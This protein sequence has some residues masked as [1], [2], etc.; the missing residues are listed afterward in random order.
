[1]MCET[2]VDRIIDSLMNSRDERFDEDLSAHLRTCDSC[3]VEAERMRLLWKQL[4]RLSVPEAKPH[5]AVEFG[6]RL[7]A[8]RR[9]RLAPLLQAAAAIALVALG[10]AVGYAGRGDGL[11]GATLPVSGEPTFMLLVRGEPQ[12]PGGPA[13]VVREYRQWAQ[14]LAADGNLVGGNKLMDE[15]GRWLTGSTVGDPR[16]NSDVTGYFLVGASDYE[17]AIEIARTSPHIRY[18]GTFEIRQVDPM[19]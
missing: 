10:A 7:S 13:S 2:A 5:A 16:T 6:R 15:P 14:S 18:G 17:E 12:A 9:S 19:N 3:S 11:D 4:G 1:M 8:S